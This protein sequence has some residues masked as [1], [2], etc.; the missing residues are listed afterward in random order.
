MPCLYWIIWNFWL[1][2][3]WIASWN[4]CMLICLNYVFLNPLLG[5]SLKYNVN[6][7]LRGQNWSMIFNDHFNCLKTVKMK[8]KFDSYEALIFIETLIRIPD[9]NTALCPTVH[10]FR[11]NCHHLPLSFQ[12]YR[13]MPD[14]DFYISFT[15]YIS[16]YLAESTDTGK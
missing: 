5:G 6:F 14:I 13:I 10:I 8:W 3:I 2:L 12:I 1:V 16:L 7:F 9:R 15:F 11:N 4:E